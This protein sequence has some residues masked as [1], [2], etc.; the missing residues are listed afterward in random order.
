[1]TGTVL[2]WR[3]KMILSDRDLKKIILNQKVYLVNPFN[4]EDLQPCSIDLHLNDE[5]KTI[6]GKSIDLSQ[7]SYKL[8]PNEFILGS[9]IEKINVPYDL[10]ARVEGKSSI[11]RLGIMIHITAGYIDAGFTGNITLEIY[12]CSNKEFELFHGDTIC[13]IAFETLSSPV[14]NPYRGKYQNSD[15]TVLSKYEGL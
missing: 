10:M 9:T 15:G 1:M 6:D 13:Q 5:L 4:E 8:K 2:I 14:E 3:G 11:A 7:D 12:N